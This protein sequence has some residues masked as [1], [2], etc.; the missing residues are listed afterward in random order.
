MVL[1]LNVKVVE[2]SFIFNRRNQ[3]DN[4]DLEFMILLLIFVVMPTYI[5]MALLALIGWICDKLDEK[6]SKK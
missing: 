1:G 5:G 6:E 2:D 3:M 4:G